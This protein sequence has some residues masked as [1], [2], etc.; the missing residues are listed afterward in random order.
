MFWCCWQLDSKRNLNSISKNCEC[1]RKACLGIWEMKAGSTISGDFFLKMNQ[2]LKM[3][4]KN[5]NLIPRKGFLRK[6]LSCPSMV[7][8]VTLVVGFDIFAG[9]GLRPSAE[10]QHFCWFFSEIESNTQNALKK[11][12]SNPKKGFFEEAPVLPVNGDGCDAGGG[13]WYFRWQWT[14]TISRMAAFLLIFLKLNPILKMLW[15]NT[16]LIPRKFLLRKR[17][18][19]PSMVMGVKM[20]VG[21]DIFVSDIAGSG[22]RPSVEWRLIKQSAALIEA[23]V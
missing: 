3:L 14:A 4:W 13:I 20:A 22:L 12:Q 7:M 11:L 23:Q 2:I 17:L 8:A 16:N 21:F 15:K 6:L 18:S 5:T 19:C 1:L 10:W 9:S